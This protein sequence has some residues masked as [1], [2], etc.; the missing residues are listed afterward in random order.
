MLCVPCYVLC[1]ML[2]NNFTLYSIQILT[3]LLTDIIKFP[4]WWYTRGFAHWG[5]TLI[6]FIKE[7]ERGIGLLV[8]IKN[9]FR[10]MYAQTDWQ[11]KL[12]SFAVR[13]VQIVFRGIVM[14][15]WILIA[16]VLFLA[17]LILPFFVIY[18]IIFQFV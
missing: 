13:L 2:Q 10:P 11:G 12:I 7:R 18:E 15:I 1:D 14:L 3:E 9:I 17:W 4:F 16:G 6:L 8:W 5:K